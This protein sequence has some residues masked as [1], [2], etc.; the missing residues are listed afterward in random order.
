MH[1]R[2]K[3]QRTPVFLPR[4]SQGRGAWWAAVYGVAQS[5][6]WLKWLSSSSIPFYGQ[7]IFHCLDIPCFVYPFISW[8]AS[9][10]FH[11][12]VTMSKDVMDIQ[13]QLLMCTYVLILLRHTPMNRIAGPYSNP[14]MDHLRNGQTVFQ[15]IKAVPLSI[16]TSKVW[17]YHFLY[18]LSNSCSYLTFWC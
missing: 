11:F 10:F 4:E 2:R 8:W 13:A 14:E 17:G 3:W 18:I 12:L 16:S 15:S 6:T 1:W 7:I 5:R 9:R